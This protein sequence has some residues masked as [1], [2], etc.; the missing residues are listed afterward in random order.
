MKNNRNA[1]IAA[2][3]IFLA[4]GFAG[5][6]LSATALNLGGADSFAV[7][8][9]S[10]IT[11]TG[12]SVINGDLGLSPGTSV[13]GFPPGIVNGAQ[14]IANA[15]A[16]Q[17][18]TDLTTAFL[19]AAAQSPAVSAASELGGTTKT[20]GLYQSADGTFAVTGTLTLDAQGDPNA[21]FIFH[22]LSTL[23]TAGASNVVL[24]N[25][26]QACNVYWE[27][28]SSATLG[29]N[30][31]FKG[32]M[33]ALT[34]ITAGTGATVEGRLLAR[35]GAVTLDTNVITKPTCTTP[36]PAPTL[37]A[38]A[39]YSGAGAYNA[40]LPLINITKIPSPL[41]LPGGP[42]LVTYTYVVTNVGV[43]GVS[44]V[45][46]RDNKCSSV[47]YISGDTNNN[48][49]LD[50]TES[51][52]YQCAKTVSATETNTATAHGWSNG[53]D[54]YANANATVV[55]GLPITPPLIHIV[56]V[57]NVFVLPAG[58]GP[59]TYTYAITNPGI[60]P[61]NTVSVT[62]N[63]C[64]LLPGLVSGNVGDLNHNNL[65]EHG[66]TWIVTCRANLTRT[67]T[68][69]ATAEGYANGLTAIAFA[70]ATVVVASSTAAYS[71]SFPN[72][73]YPPKK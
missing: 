16:V 65:L 4:L 40:P 49:M 58:G 45:W 6:A 7:L 59:V 25:G 17:A 69:I 1:A 19:A 20:A 37:T 50:T 32:S 13:T 60:A 72:T 71:P 39:S 56:K 3:G 62:D 12:T 70:P 38:T 55:V 28:D 36:P 9:G 43:V 11:N 31:T 21:V 15:A 46:V 30:S 42:G 73:G 14:Q 47:I 29:T 66:E 48:S 33:L 57:P 41:N 53:W 24:I 18:K 2:L 51:W 68:N 22:A 5:L 52:T 63:K 26:A 8:A 44:D 27:V 61:L 34:S 23:T 35:N 10:T 67:T 64:S 54:G